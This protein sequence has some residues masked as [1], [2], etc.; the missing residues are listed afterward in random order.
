[1]YFAVGG[2][3]SI[4]GDSTIFAQRAATAQVPVYLDI[5]NAMWHVFPMYSEGCQN[6]DGTALWQ[7]WS[8]LHRSADF[9]RGVAAGGPPC[10]PT[11]GR[12]STWIH[13]S[14]AADGGGRNREWFP[15]TLCGEAPDI[16]NPLHKRSLVELNRDLILA[17]CGS[18]L[19]ATCGLVIG[20]SL[21][22]LLVRHLQR[23]RDQFSERQ[24]LD[25]SSHCHS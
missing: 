16:G 1:M 21:H 9:L 19:L 13:Y 23:Q 20:L 3:E 8:A 5:Y 22:V 4:L 17:T 25:P 18:F 14:E 24:G 6:P 15:A 11:P 10:P 2:S 7:A 12:P